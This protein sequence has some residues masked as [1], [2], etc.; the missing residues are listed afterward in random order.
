M[1][2]VPRIKRACTAQGPRIKGD[3]KLPLR[4]FPPPT[5]RLLM[6]QYV[7][8]WQNE[9]SKKTLSEGPFVVCSLMGGHRVEVHWG[10][11]F[12]PPGRILSDGCFI[13]PDS[14]I[15]NMMAR[16]KRPLYNRRELD[17]VEEQVDYL[18]ELVCNGNIKLH[19]CGAW[20]WGE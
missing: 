6:A 12:W 4:T 1:C 2:G 7:G 15:Y 20:V 10:Q 5:K 14:T 16:I 19:E 13:L 18:N 9:P 17:I 8:Y 3:P 11:S